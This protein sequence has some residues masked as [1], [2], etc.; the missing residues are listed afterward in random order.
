MSGK[1]KAKAPQILNKK[2]DDNELVKYD[3]ELDTVPFKRFNSAEMS[4]FFAI[5]SQMRNKRTQTIRFPFS[6][7]KKLSQYSKKSL[8]SFVKV[9]HNTYHK[10][11]A[12]TIYNKQEG[13][14]DEWVLF[15]HFHISTKHKVVDISVN[16]DPKM[17]AILNNITRWTR[18]S[19]QQ[20]NSLSSSYA[21]TIFRL[22][23]KFRTQG[24]CYLNMKNFRKQLNIPKSYGLSHI[25][26]K[27]LKPSRRQLRKKIWSDFDYQKIKSKKRG[28]RVL[29][30]KFLFQKE[31]H[32]NKD[33]LTSSIQTN[34]KD[35]RRNTH[36]LNKENLKEIGK[37]KKPK[38]C[39]NEQANKI[40]QN[41]L[42]KKS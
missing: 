26:E 34:F 31:A 30:F 41:F 2:Y 28:N 25:D 22:C 4:I 5:V 1:S 23:K 7:L 10:M 18:F 15:T 11:L 33:I 35:M 14:Y 38:P 29:G 37:R 39:S 42:K 8:K 32:N 16:P 24:Y 40:Y 20:F 13:E 12:L 19:L 21:K 27:V 3:N 17:Q 36:V 6:D 9:L